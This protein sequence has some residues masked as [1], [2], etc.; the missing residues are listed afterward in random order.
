MSDYSNPINHALYKR[1]DVIY[2][3]EIFKDKNNKYYGRW[4]CCSN[5]QTGNSNS[6]KSDIKSVIVDNKINID[7]YHSHTFGTKSSG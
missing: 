7:S 2:E 6:T 3:I 1:G 5:N 4:T